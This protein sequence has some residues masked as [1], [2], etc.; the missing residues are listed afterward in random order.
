MATDKEAITRFLLMGQIAAKTRVPP[1][2]GYRSPSS[3]PVN[4]QGRECDVL[5]FNPAVA[6][7]LWKTATPKATAR[8]MIYYPA[9]VDSRLLAEI[10]QHQWRENLGLETDLQARE[11]G[12]YDRSVFQLGDFNGVAEDSY[13]ANFADPHD[14]LG[15]FAADYPSWSDRAFEEKLSGATAITNPALRMKELAECEASLL[16]AMPVIPLYYDNW[17]YLER[18]DLHGLGLNP[19]GIPAF[20]YAWIE[21]TRRIQ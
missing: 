18:P 20:K 16:R 15:V 12:V 2:P 9:G 1:L 17:V 4:V 11:P 14:F 6:R 13:M 21:E 10:Q 5:E 7:E 3:V 19:I 8:L